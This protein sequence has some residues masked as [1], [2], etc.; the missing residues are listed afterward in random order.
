M[1]FFIEFVLELVLD[2]FI[3]GSIEVSSNHP[4][5]TIGSASVIFCGCH[6]PAVL[7]GRLP[8]AGKS[9]GRHSNVCARI[10]LSDWGNC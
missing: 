8:A 9:G 1:D 10:V 3:E 2:L 6:F 4:L 5:S 7:F